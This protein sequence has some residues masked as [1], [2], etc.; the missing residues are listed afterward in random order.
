MSV[1]VRFY[2]RILSRVDV[3]ENKLHRDVDRDDIT[4][5][6]NVSE[7]K[8]MSFI[9][10]AI[11]RFLSPRIPRHRVANGEIYRTVKRDDCQ[12]E[13]LYSAWRPTLLES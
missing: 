3:L 13:H 11:T 12:W 7:R 8:V 5:I 2:F 1:A 6:V 9:V 4:Q 10:R